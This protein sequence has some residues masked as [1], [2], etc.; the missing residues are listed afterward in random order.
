M[1]ALVLLLPGCATAPG[2]VAPAAVPAQYANVP[3]FE[4]GGKITAPK[5]TQ[6]VA[7]IAPPDFR[8]ERQMASAVAEIVID[9]Q[10][11]V[12]DAWYVDGDRRWADI[13]ITAMRQWKFE[14]ATLNGQPIMVR[15]R[16]TSSF[17][18]NM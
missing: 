4:P 9:Q 1:T 13:F 3:L 5:L 10:G 14:P 16:M 2:V 7:P 6:R 15:S 8:A 12:V 18:N 11:N 17:R